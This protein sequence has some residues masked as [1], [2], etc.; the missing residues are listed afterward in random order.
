MT[1]CFPISRQSRYCFPNASFVFLKWEEFLIAKRINFA[2]KSLEL[3]SISSR[4]TLATFT[5]ISIF[6]FFF[7]IS[8]AQRKN[9]T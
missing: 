1:N 7:F 6:L 2:I 8:I 4:K 5:G 9:V 3:I